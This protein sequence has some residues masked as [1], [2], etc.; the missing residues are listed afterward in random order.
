MFPLITPQPEPK[1]YESEFEVMERNVRWHEAQQ[2]KPSRPGLFERF[3]NLLAR[4][5]YQPALDPCVSTATQE[6]PAISG[7]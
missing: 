1:R 6:I 7:C 3:A 4:Q 2:R 5:N